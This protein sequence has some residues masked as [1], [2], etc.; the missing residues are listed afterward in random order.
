MKSSLIW[1]LAVVTVLGCGSVQRIGQPA[2]PSP[3]AETATVSGHVSWPDCSSTG[4]ACS[5]VAGVPVHFADASAN[6]T[7]TAVSDGSGSYDI[8][9]PAGSYQVIAGNADRSPY[10]RQLTVRPGDVVKLDLSISLPTG[11]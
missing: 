1:L 6:R 7:F 11:A 4:P 9:L 10:Q 5:S 8:R 3:G 2:T